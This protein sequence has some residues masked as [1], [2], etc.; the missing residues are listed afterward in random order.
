MRL[1]RYADGAYFVPGGELLWLDLDGQTIGVHSRE[2]YLHTDGTLEPGVLES[3]VRTELRCLTY[4]ADGQPGG[5]PRFQPLVCEA[6]GDSGDDGDSDWGCRSCDGHG[7]E[8]NLYRCSECGDFSA[9]V[10]PVH[11]RAV[12]GHPLLI[13]HAHVA[14]AIESLRDPVVREGAAA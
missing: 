10:L 3:P 14:C 8:R 2:P 7:E 13:P 9:E 11:P 5:S 6:C 1:A 12:M 4:G